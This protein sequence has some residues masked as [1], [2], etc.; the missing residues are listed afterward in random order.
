[1]TAQPETRV[2]RLRY[3][4]T[5]HCGTA[6]DA[7]E[8]GAYSRST[9]TVTCLPCHE[10]SGQ[11]ALSSPPAVPTED[12]QTPQ[13]PALDVGTA[14]AAALKEYE[15]RKAKDEAARQERSKV[16]RALNGFF[17][18]D[19]R[20][21]THAWKVGAA[22]EARVAEALLKCTESGLGYAL[23][24]RRVPGKRSNI[25]HLFVGASGVFVID[26]KY[27]KNAEVS[28]ERSGGLFG[29]TAETLKVSGRKR[30]ALVTAMLGQRDVV[31][32]ALAGTAAEVTPVIPVLCFV[33]GIL[34][35]RE[36]NRRVI[37]V[38][39]CGLKGLSALA[40]LEGRL[41]DA[42]RLEVARIVA[43]KLPSMT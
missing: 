12:L 22:G 17:Y 11:D 10:A 37:G 9:R 26:A 31:V 4:A 19:G 6:V 5:C 14:G 8:R 30:D 33:D 35:M 43:A 34:P 29:P 25:D 2:M 23:H 20:Q 32:D 41:D 18:P 27:Y 3:A 36:K 40:A 21:T 42:R 39:L 38:R 16:W 28:V 13:V 15:R 7:G 24:D 1:M